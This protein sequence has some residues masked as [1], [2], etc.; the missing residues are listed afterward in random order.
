MI[1]RTCARDPLK[2]LFIKIRYGI[3]DGIRSLNPTAFISAMTASRFPRYGADSTI[4]AVIFSHIR[5]CEGTQ[6]RRA[7]P[8]VAIQFARFCIVVSFGIAGETVLAAVS[9]PSRPRDATDR[10]CLAHRAQRR[11]RIINR[12]LHTCGGIPLVNAGFTVLL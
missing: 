11:D 2:A 5:H 7:V 4:D 12:R 6:L 9:P 1:A 3:S 8:R 10:S